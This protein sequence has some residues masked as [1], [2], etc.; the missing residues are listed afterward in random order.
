MTLASDFFYAVPYTV[1]HRCI[2]PRIVPQHRI[3]PPPCFLL[4]FAHV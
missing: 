1:A 4:A 3:R 2:V